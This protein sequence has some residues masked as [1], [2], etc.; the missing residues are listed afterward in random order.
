MSDLSDTP[1]E[2]P[3]RYRC[4]CGSAMFHNFKY[5]GPNIGANCVSCGARVKSWIR[6]GD[7]GLESNRKRRGSIDRQEVLARYKHR[8]AWCGVAAKDLPEGEQLDMGHII[9]HKFLLKDFE[10]LLENPANFA[11]TCAACNDFA[12]K[13]M[14]ESFDMTL[15]MNAAL[16]YYASKS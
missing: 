10:G 12:H 11:P 2:L 13:V 1:R 7:L 3:E 5:H 6:R 9:P 4:D 16:A 15:L 14:K 8:C